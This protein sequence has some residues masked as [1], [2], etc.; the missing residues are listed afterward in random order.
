MTD[1]DALEA[2]SRLAYAFELL[3]A[4]SA[5]A[6]R[7]ASVW[8]DRKHQDE[9]TYTPVLEGGA[10]STSSTMVSSFDIWPSKAEG[11]RLLAFRAYVEQALILAR[12]LSD[13]VSRTTSP[14]PDDVLACRLVETQA[15]NCPVSTTLTRSCENVSTKRAGFT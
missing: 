9:G 4:V 15:S 1:E 12:Q 5:E 13:V 2:L 7:L 11:T 8:A 14:K 10:V 3:A 6:I